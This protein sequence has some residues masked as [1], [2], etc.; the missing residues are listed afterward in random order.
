MK[1]LLFCLGLLLSQQILF[2]Q[3]C[4]QIEVATDPAK[5]ALLN[6][7]VRECGTKHYFFED[8]GVV[9]LVIYQDKQGLTRWHLSALVD[10]R[11]RILP[12]RDYAQ[13]GNN[14]ILVY[15]GDT[16]GS[17]LPIAGNAT[18]RDACMQEVVGGRVYERSTRKQVI[19]V[20]QENGNIERVPVTYLSGGNSHN[21]LIIRFN[22]DGTI[23][24]FLPV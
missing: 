16:E 1:S 24:K 12:P 21:E 9:K 18:A 8:K 14:I 5:T 7:Y 23:T 4:Q 2:A 15:Q 19:N 17:P 10:D 3:T 20:R 22:K 13:L 11:Y 6:E